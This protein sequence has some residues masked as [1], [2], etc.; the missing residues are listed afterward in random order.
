[1]SHPADALT[2]SARLLSIQPLPPAEANIQPG[3]WRRDVPAAMLRQLVNALV[4]AVRRPRGYA[5]PGLE[6]H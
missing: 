2:T 1:M 3:L 5:H 4:G 6:P